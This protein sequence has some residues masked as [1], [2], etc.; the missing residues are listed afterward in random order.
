MRSSYG[1]GSGKLTGCFAQHKLFLI[2]LKR[3]AVSKFQ[4]LE[5]VKT[6][7]RKSGRQLTWL[8]NKRQG[9][10]G[11]RL[12][13][14]EVLNDRCLSFLAHKLSLWGGNEWGRATRFYVL[15]SLR[16]RE[17][18]LLQQINVQDLTATHSEE[19]LTNKMDQGGSLLAAEIGENLRGWCWLV[20]LEVV[21]LLSKWRLTSCSLMD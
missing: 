20:A 17:T 10:D 11:Q 15:W 7:W 9:P 14:K 18:A 8:W 19:V 16:K 6:S 4:V 3:S 21:A 1:A 12:L 2:S 5:S 13:G